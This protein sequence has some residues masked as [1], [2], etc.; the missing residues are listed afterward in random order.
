MIPSLSQAPAAGMPKVPETAM[1]E[2]ARSLEAAFLAEMLRHA[3]L[4]TGEGPWQGGAAAAQFASFLRGAQ[5]EQMVAAGG[6]GLAESLFRA[7]TEA[8]R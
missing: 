2:A 7:M 8:G 1:Q 6:I 4:G 3:G 5:A